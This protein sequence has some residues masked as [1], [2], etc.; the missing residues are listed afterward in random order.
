MSAPAIYSL[1]NELLIAIAVAGQEGDGNLQ[2]TF[3][4]EWTL[5]H[6]SRRFRD[7][8]VGASALW[9]HID[10]DL[11][12][13]GSFEILKL[14]L[15]RSQAYYI[16]VTLRSSLDMW[17]TPHEDSTI[18]QRLYEI[19]PHLYHIVKLKIILETLG[20]AEVLSGPFRDVVAPHLQHLEII[21]ADVDDW[22]PTVEMFSPGAPRLRSLRIDGVQLQLP[23]AQWTASLTHLN[24]R[25]TQDLNDLA[26]DPYLAITA[27]CPLLAHLQLDMTWMSAGAEQIYIPTLKSLYI[28]ISDSEDN[29]HLLGILD[30]FD[31]P[32]LTE[33]MV[34]GTH[35]DQISTLFN[36]ASLPRS[37]FPALTSI[38]FVQRG[39]CAC[40][41]DLPFS[42]DALSSPPLALF[43]ALTSLTLI[44]QC[45]THTLVEDILGPASEP[46]PLLRTVTLC[47]MK[48]T[49]EKVCDALKDAVQ[50]DR[51]HHI[52]QLRLS[53]ALLSREDWREIGVDVEVFDPK[54]V[55]GNFW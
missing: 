20:E 52:P 35:G 33:F 18:V 36:S 40:E 1:P 54:D 31:T 46:W 29:I 32:A 37:S 23:T 10:T 51:E 47:P 39:T 22:K 12:L 4:P 11:D 5:S 15:E 21:V 42:L 25:R 30:I 8:I 13:V 26:D 50:S 44:N 2:W 27:Q 19:V 34:E 16:S 48:D 9:A 17:K 55:L 41:F 38:S 28:S 14:Y 6:V 3:K 49:V 53:S 7:V 43:P 24:L 45:F